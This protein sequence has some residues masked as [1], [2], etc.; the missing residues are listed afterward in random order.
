MIS[1]SGEVFGFTRENI[2]LPR[3][4]IAVTVLTNQEASLQ[5]LGP[6]LEFVEVAKE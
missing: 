2:I 1:H 6:P 5:P 3:D 4:K